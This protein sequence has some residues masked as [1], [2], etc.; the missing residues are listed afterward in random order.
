VTDLSTSDYTILITLTWDTAVVAVPVQGNADSND[1]DMGIWDDP[2]NPD[3]GPNQDGIRALG[4]TGNMP[5]KM[6]LVDASG[7][8]NLVV[9]NSS[10]V[11]HGYHLEI[12]WKTQLLSTPF[13]SLPP[14]FST[15]GSITPPGR[16]SLGGAPAPAPAAAPAPAP[17]AATALPALPAPAGDTAFTS[18]PA[19]AFNDQ[20]TTNV[21]NARPATAKRNLQ[22]PSNLALLLWLIALPF[23]LT[24]IGGQL[25]LGRSRS[26]LRI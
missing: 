21:I 12:S 10:G 9:L 23:G 18:L 16:L 24:A 3:A 7:N 1:L 26:L 19:S 8:F 17:A 2:V 25:L 15:T 14:D 5:E 4:A 6:T 22:P 20:L 11:N 13:E